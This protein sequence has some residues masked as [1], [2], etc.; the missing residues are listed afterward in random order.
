MKSL[1]GKVV[2]ITGAASGI[3]R[4]TAVLLAR[5]GARLAISDV[6]EAGL[7]ETALLCGEAAVRQSVVDVSRREAVEQWAAETVQH[8]G[9]AHVIVN[10]AGVALGATIEAT[11]YEDFQ[12]LMGINFWG[13]VHGTKAF[14]PHLRAAGEGHIVNVSSLFG[15][16][17]FPAQGAYVAAKFAVRGFTE[18]LRQELQIEGAPIGVTQVHPGGIKTNIARNARNRVD[19]RFVTDSAS[20]DFE[21]LFTTTAE[22]AAAEIRSAILGNRHRQLI[23]R[24]A[25]FMDLMQRLAPVLYSSLIVNQARKRFLRRKNK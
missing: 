15:L 5:D 4:A 22:T 8:Y 25:K 21:K 6:N 11:D 23:G 3:G 14:L 20:R 19:G 7:R 10:N 17:A 2:A 1:Q 13:V 18:T 24:D 16:V 9:A 12:W